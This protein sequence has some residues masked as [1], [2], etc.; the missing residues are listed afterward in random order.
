LRRSRGLK[1]AKIMK[2]RK[3]EFDG[4]NPNGQKSDT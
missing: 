3:L 4:N 1:P 2:T